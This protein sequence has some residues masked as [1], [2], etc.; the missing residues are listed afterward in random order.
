MTIAS[1]PQTATPLRDAVIRRLASNPKLDATAI[2]VEASGGIITLTGFVDNY[3]AKHEAERVA[4]QV[5]GVRAVA[6]NLVVRLPSYRP[7]AEIAGDVK[8]ALQLRPSTA[9][10]LQAVV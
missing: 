5:R 7:D 4:R 1:P 2:G 10:D 9:R 6:N 8:R 3:T